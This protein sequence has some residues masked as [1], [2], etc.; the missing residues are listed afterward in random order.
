MTTAPS[1]VLQ[2][3]L[4]EHLSVFD[5]AFKPLNGIR[6]IHYMGHLKMMGAVQP[7]ILR[8]DFKDSESAIGSHRG[9]N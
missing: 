3:L 9:G 8:S 4:D 1:K 5:C 7:F 6:S 2:G